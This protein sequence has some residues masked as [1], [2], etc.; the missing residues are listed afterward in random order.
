MEALR[1]RSSQ[2]TKAAATFYLP[3]CWLPLMRIRSGVRNMFSGLRHVSLR[4]GY[5]ACVYHRRSCKHAW[6]FTDATVGSYEPSR[7]GSTTSGGSRFMRL[8]IRL[9]YGLRFR[10]MH[11]RF[12]VSYLSRA[13]S[14][15]VLSG[16]VILPG[17]NSICEMC[18]RSVR[19]GFEWA[20]SNKNK[21][22]KNA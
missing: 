17:R 18:G 10:T 2:R 15:F 22:N 12:M 7:R 21:Q 13:V 16:M 1:L 9:H 6:V 20:R 19:P 8:I 11:R 3:P 14:A 4:L 5:F